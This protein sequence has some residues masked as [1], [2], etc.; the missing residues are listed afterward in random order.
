M[1]SNKLNILIYSDESRRLEKL[2]DELSKYDY[3]KIEATA[4]EIMEMVDKVVANSAITALI[5][6]ISATGQVNDFMI[7]P[8]QAD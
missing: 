1:S 6:L 4:T 3:V 5:L 7:E 2:K 8:I